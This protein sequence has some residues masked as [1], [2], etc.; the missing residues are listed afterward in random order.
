MKAE[1]VNPFYQAT[2]NVFKLMLD[3]DVNRDQSKVLHEML[4]NKEI[5]V[6]IDITGDLTGRI[7]YRFPDTTI[8]EM[9]KIMSGMEFD[10]VDSFVTSALGEVSNIISGNAVSSLFDQNY[11]CDIKPP[12]IIIED[13][14]PICLEGSQVLKIPL[15]TAIGKLQIHL[16]LKENTA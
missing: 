6:A 11:K 1:Y 8:L 10:T 15:D 13:E 12:Q 5:G 4:G 3:I 16:T 2:I 7:L 14:K 9:V